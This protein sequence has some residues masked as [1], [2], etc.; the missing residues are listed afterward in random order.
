MTEFEKTF[1]NY[2]P[3]QAALDE[4]RA[5]LTEAARAAMAAGE[6]PEAELPWRAPAPAARPPA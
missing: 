2:N 5:F 4:A 6:L 1:V 3:R